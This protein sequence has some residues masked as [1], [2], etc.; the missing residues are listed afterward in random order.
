M[1]AIK[2]NLSVAKQRYFYERI[3]AIAVICVKYTAFVVTVPLFL[4]GPYDIIPLDVYVHTLF[5]KI[6]LLFLTE[7]AYVSR[8]WQITAHCTWQNGLTGN[9]RGG[10]ISSARGL[11]CFHVD[12]FIKIYIFAL[13][14][15][16]FK[17]QSTVRVKTPF[18]LIKTLFNLI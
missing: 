6:K 10:V 12:S 13:L 4:T 15:N 11:F 14:K 2:L 7:A 3:A 8:S 9:N 17:S 1:T 5:H 16:K 18:E